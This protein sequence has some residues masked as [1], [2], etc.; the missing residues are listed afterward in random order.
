VR[1]S[2]GVLSRQPLDRALIVGPLV[3]DHDHRHRRQPGLDRRQRAPVA[4]LDPKRS[5]ARADR[6]D[7][8]QVAEVL[9][10]RDEVLVGRRL[11]SHVHVDQQ[12]RRVDLHHAHPVNYRRRR[13]GWFGGL[14][15]E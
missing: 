4:G 3:G 15:H 2:F 9:D 1:C 5:L 11:A 6:P 8:L 7:R 10:R 12:R 13:G 14:S